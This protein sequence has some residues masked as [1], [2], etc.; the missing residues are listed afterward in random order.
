[1]I[2]RADKRFTHG[3]MLM[4]SYTWSHMREQVTPL[5]PWEEPEE[6]VAAV[7]RPHRI[8]FAS[9]AELPVGRDRRWGANWIPIVDADS[10]RM[11]VQRE[12]R[13]AGR[14]AAGIQQQHLLRSRVRRSESS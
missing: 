7:D 12:V 3:F 11:A 10:R 8:T 2:F 6:R 9:V 14:P 13:M 4:S 1:M 5:N